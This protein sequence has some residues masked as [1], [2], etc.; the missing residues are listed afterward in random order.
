[1]RN[2]GTARFEFGPLVSDA[3]FVQ[4]I[5]DADWFVIS[6]TQGAGSS[7]LPSKLIPCISLG[8]PILTISDRSG[9]LGREVAEHRLGVAL[10]WSQMDQLPIRLRHFQEV[11][12]AFAELQQQLS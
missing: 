10:E 8:T 3:E 7:F 9:P 12:E 1:M 6:E 5:H 11:P 2:K 4:A